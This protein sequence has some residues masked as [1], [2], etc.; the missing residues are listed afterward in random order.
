MWRCRFVILF[1]LLALCT[2]FVVGS[3]WFFKRFVLKRISSALACRI[4]V[5][6]AGWNPIAG[7][8]LR[9]VKVTAI[10]GD[11]I[12]SF[13]KLDL[14]FANPLIQGGWIVTDIKMDR[15]AITV[16]RVGGVSNVDSI[17]TAINKLLRQKKKGGD[18]GELWAV[19]MRVNDGEFQLNDTQDGVTNRIACSGINIS[20][21][22][23]DG[24]RDIHLS[25]KVAISH[26]TPTNS[27]T[28]EQV[29]LSSIF[30]ADISLIDGFK[31]GETKLDAVIESPRC[32]GLLSAFNA[33]RI[34]VNASGKG[35]AIDRL[36]LRLTDSNGDV[37]DI[38]GSGQFNWRTF[39]G[40]IEFETQTIGPRWD[41]IYPWLT[42]LKLDAEVVR[43]RGAIGS[44]G[45][46][47]AV[48]LRGEFKAESARVILSDVERKGLTLAGGFAVDFRS[49][50]GLRLDEIFVQATRPDG[51]SLSARLVEPW[52]LNSSAAITNK[53][54]WRFVLDEIPIG[55]LLLVK[56]NSI[57]VGKVNADIVTT[58]GL[59]GGGFAF[60]GSGEIRDLGMTVLGNSFSNILVTAEMVGRKQTSGVK[61]DS[62]HLECS[63][64]SDR[65]LRLDF[66]GELDA[67]KQSWDGAGAVELS[68]L[69]LKHV[70]V[71]KSLPIEFTRLYY[72]G[73]L[74]L[75][76]K[77]KLDIQTNSINGKL[78]WDGELSGNRKRVMAGKLTTETTLTSAGKI[79]VRDVIGSFTI[80]EKP[81]TTFEGS[82]NIDLKNST[83][84]LAARKIDLGKPILDWI[85]ESNPSI[86][87]VDAQSVLIDG[88][89]ERSADRLFK[90]GG[91]L[92]FHQPKLDLK[93]GAMTVASCSMAIEMEMARTNAV[94]A[95]RLAKLDARLH[96]DGKPVGQVL[97]DGNFED[98]ARRGHLK[99]H[100]VEVKRLILDPWIAQLNPGINV[101]G[102]NL[103][104]V[105]NWSWAQTHRMDVAGKF[106]SFG[107]Q[108]G[109][110]KSDGANLAV[111]FDVAGRFPGIR[112]ADQ[113]SL[114]DKFE[115]GFSGAENFKGKVG[116]TISL[117]ADPTPFAID[118]RQFEATAGT[119]ELF[120]GINV[121]LLADEKNWIK[122]REVNVTT[123][124][125]YAEFH[126]LILPLHLSGAPRDASISGRLEWNDK[127]VFTGKL[128]AEYPHLNLDELIAKLI[129]ADA[130]RTNGSTNSLAKIKSVP[131]DGL[132]LNLGISGANWKGIL[133]TNINSRILFQ[134]NN[135]EVRDVQ[136]SVNDTPVSGGAVLRLPLDESNHSIRLESK[137]IPLSAV[138][139]AFGGTNGLGRTE[140]LTFKADFTKVR[141]DSQNLLRSLTGRV[142]A[143]VEDI[144]VQ[145]EGPYVGLARI[146]FELIRAP[147]IM[148]EP[149]RRIEADFTFD[150]GTVTNEVSLSTAA[151]TAF[152]SGRMKL[153]DS[154]Q[155]SSI[156]QPVRFS[157]SSVVAKKFKVP[158]LERRENFRELRSFY[159]IGGTI[160]SPDFKIN[161]PI[162]VELFTRATVRRVLGLSTGIVESAADT[163]ISV[164]RTLLGPILKQE[165]NNLRMLNPVRLFESILNAVLPSKSDIKQPR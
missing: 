31:L 59:E 13:D 69:G 41:R 21:A 45:D 95:G 12:A 153:A 29:E 98:S 50:N 108:V 17:R 74:K 149:I 152:V 122:P 137:S 44:D 97:I 136:A 18:N 14:T 91:N 32:G 143:Y 23:T 150:S 52:L 54:K 78:E 109:G 106:D 111:A 90:A 3:G 35:D 61:F 119:V 123:G 126:K 64:K 56:T 140:K 34:A 66:S 157:L 120:S 28:G 22:R 46:K 43:A 72:E 8:Q 26:S 162:A 160:E 70:A 132:T 65:L 71:G 112:S 164:P 138:A 39:D 79:V 36:R 163:L 118:V 104:A 53:S 60:D 87:K 103:Q 135:I 68:Q 7:A 19:R 85:R 113:K 142:I 155:E 92:T 96:N 80:D 63:E 62:I 105:G 24:R 9:G 165:S 99:F 10:N 130:A 33:T 146:P 100:A 131:L 134:P 94:W 116:G 76:L 147:E 83:G 73:K 86:A 82:G 110:R 38:S 159:S 88:S 30:A 93:Q 107:I 115:L 151:W 25:G 117:H 4:T 154:W 144:E 1:A 20:G 81:A 84:K 47:K 129:R 161:Y 121:S 51:A 101:E 57:N 49:T 139:A 11:P 58:F 16:K 27:F 40:A 145:L 158:L 127:S 89:V 37:A 77:D 42:G 125:G 6:Q 48:V 2:Y 128:S 5:E 141:F 148:K 15:P 67:D 156:E 55:E 133:M 102:G 124:S 75:A 114:L